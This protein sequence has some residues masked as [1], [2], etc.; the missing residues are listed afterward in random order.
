MGTA[1]Q[2]GAGDDNGALTFLFT[3]IAD[4]L[5]NKGYAIL[6]D[7]LPDSLI[8]SLERC[9]YSM[10]DSA[11][12]QAGIGRKQDFQHDQRIRRDE[13]CWIDGSMPEGQQW[14]G[15]CESLKDF[16]NQQLF[17]GLFSVES[18]FARFESGAFYKRHYDAFRGQDNRV[19]SMV[20]YLNADWQLADGGELVLYAD[21]ADCEGTAVLPR[22]GTLVIF[23]SERFPHEV[24]PARKT[25]ESVATWFR[26]NT[27]RPGR[28]DPPR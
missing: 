4:D 10:L 27:T 8:N 1:I 24:K 7:A 9:Q 11:F 21:D 5:V 19:L 6:P 28:V 18:H 3:R 12:E 23:L 22:R 17:M 25:R 15:F 16:L 26:L 13:I 20:T 2:S 14:L